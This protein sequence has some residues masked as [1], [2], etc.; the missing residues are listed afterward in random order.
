[1]NSKQDVMTTM[2]NIIQKLILQLRE[3]VPQEVPEAGEFDIVYERVSNPDRSLDVSDF[4]LKV[5]KPPKEIPGT[6]RE[7]YLEFV[8]YSRSSP[9][10]CESVVGFGSKADILAKLH[11]PDLLPVLL[12]KIPEMERDLNDI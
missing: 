10:M 9:Y 4:M 7:R 6:E 5:T 1:M 12:K 3:R 11:D 8:L 2:M